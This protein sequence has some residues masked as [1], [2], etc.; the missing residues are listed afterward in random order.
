MIDQSDLQAGLQCSSAAPTLEIF[1]T[2]MLAAPGPYHPEGK[3]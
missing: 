3:L 1:G 2:G